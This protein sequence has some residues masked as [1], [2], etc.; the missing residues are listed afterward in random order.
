[1]PMPACPFCSADLSAGARPVNGRVVCPRCGESVAAPDAAVTP[2]PMVAAP[3][4]S[5]RGQPDA[6]PTVPLR[7]LWPLALLG[8]AMTLVVGAI[9]LY[10]IL[11]GNSRTAEA[12]PSPPIQGATRVRLPAEPARVPGLGY[13]PA[14][15]NAVVALQLGPLADE[16]ARAGKSPRDLL[17]EAGVPAD[18]LGVLADAGVPLDALEAAAL[19]VSFAPGELVPRSVLV[20]TGRGSL[21][22]M[23]PS[24]VTTS[25]GGNAVP[26]ARG[27]LGTLSAL[28]ARLKARPAPGRRGVE[29]G[30]LR[31]ITVFVATPAEDT[32]VLATTLADAPEPGRARPWRF[33]E[34]FAPALAQLSARPYGYAVT[35]RV[36]WDKLPLVA[37]AAQAKPPR[38]KLPEPDAGGIGAM[39]AELTLAPALGV[40]AKYERLRGDGAGWREWGK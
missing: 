25:S 30:E 35:I 27:P 21:G 7:A 4:I 33:A 3:Y 36:P 1:M 20:L 17:S 32:L 6:E 12:P 5:A 2:L 28:R 19:G 15:V 14:D 31:G 11:G 23:T 16:A 10:A 37:L 38:L 18:L 40:A 24:S 22:D 13:L 39:A 26:A 29:Q 9:T 8:A 34:A